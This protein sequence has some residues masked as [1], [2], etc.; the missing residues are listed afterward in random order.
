[1]GDK[2]PINPVGEV[3]IV[4]GGERLL[5]SL[6][7]VK[8][9]SPALKGGLVG[10]LKGGLVGVGNVDSG[11][12][13]LER[14]SSSFDCLRVSSLVSSSSESKSSLSSLSP[15]RLVNLNRP[16]PKY[17]ISACSSLSGGVHNQSNLPFLSGLSNSFGS[18]M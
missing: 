15:S 13:V 7:P 17:N 16:A 1:M 9:K 2:S 6:K 10:G 4:G 14:I 18:K 11:D 5:L 12:G 8:S 3:G